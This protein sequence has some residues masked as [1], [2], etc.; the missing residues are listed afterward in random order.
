MAVFEA[1]GTDDGLPAH[2]ATDREKARIKWILVDSLCH[3]ERVGEKH[4][5]PLGSERLLE[6]NRAE[7]VGLGADNLAL[8]VARRRA[9]FD[10]FPFAW[11]R[12]FSRRSFSTVARS[13][14]L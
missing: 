11:L 9:A 10:L 3:A 6:F 1:D 5:R 12:A 4:E 7:R 8:I 14:P 13:S 2:A